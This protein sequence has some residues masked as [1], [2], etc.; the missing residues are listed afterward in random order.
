MEFVLQN[1]PL[2]LLPGPRTDIRKCERAVRLCIACGHCVAACP[3]GA[4][5]L[6]AMSPAECLPV[7]RELD[8]GADALEQFLK[9]RRS[10]RNYKSQIVPR[11]T[12]TRLLDTTRWAPSAKNEQPVHWMVIESPPEV[13]KLAGL[14]V[15]WLR[16]TRNYPGIVS[17]WEQG[18]D[19]VL[20][21][22]PHLVIAS[23]HPDNSK[24]DVDCAIALTYLDLAANALGLG[25][26]W[27]GIL[28]NA[29][30]EHRP[31]IDALN[32]PEHHKVYGAM[33]LGLPAYSYFR[34]P[35]RQVAKVVWR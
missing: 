12:L 4:L 20:R 27:A 10:C 15:E 5:S 34:I 35:Q 26:C 7:R 9:S 8:I 16:E 13:H 31:L 33:M 18:H 24:P 29:A 22:A 6:G 3:T 14:T 23:A 17:A 32:L 30:K 19:M 11:E 21:K 1:V 28:M 2:A 25:T